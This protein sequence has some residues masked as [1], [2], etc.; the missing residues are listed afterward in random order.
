MRLKSHIFV[1]SLLRRAFSLGGYAAVLRKGAEDA[2]AIFIRQR[3]RLGTE[4]LFAPA[5]QNFFADEI[6][7]GRKF[8]VRL[9]DS[10]AEQVDAALASEIRFD[11]D[12]WIVEIEL[13]DRGDL[14]EVVA[15][16]GKGRP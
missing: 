8:E 10:D 15:E 5:P 16:D 13:D 4:T 14:F 12:C 11:P 2:G 7:L 1:S 3:T 9:S 6:D